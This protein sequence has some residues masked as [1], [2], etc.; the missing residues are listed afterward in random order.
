MDKRYLV[1]LRLRGGRTIRFRVPVVRE[2]YD[3]IKGRHTAALERSRTSPIG[4]L[5]DAKRDL[6]RWVEQVRNLVSGGY[7]REVATPD[8]LIRVAEDPAADAEQRIGAAV[9]GDVDVKVLKRAL[10]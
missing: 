4:A 10:G 9:E 5:R 1:V 7:R 6:P 8:V 2:F 3:E